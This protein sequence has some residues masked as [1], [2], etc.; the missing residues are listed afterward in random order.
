MKRLK[1]YVRVILHFPLSGYVLRAITSRRAS[2]S[3]EKPSERPSSV[4]I[5]NLIPF[6]GDAVLYLPLVDALKRQRPDIKLSVICCETVSSL[7]SEY[8]GI[9]EVLIVKSVKHAWMQKVPIM[10]DYHRFLTVAFFVRHIGKSR[11]FDVGLIP[12][13][14]AEPF[15]S[16]HAAWLMEIPRIYGYSSKLEPERSFM[17]Y[18]AE[19][20]MSGV[21]DRKGHLHESMRAL[22][23]GELAGLISSG[24]WSADGAIDGLK[25]LASQ[26]NFEEI[27]SKVGL[28]PDDEYAV[29]APGAGAARRQWPAERFREIVRRLEEITDMRILIIGS[30]SELSI[31]EAIAQGFGTRA[32]CIA[33]QLTLPQLVGLLSRARIF[34][35]N[36]SGPGH[37]AGGLGVPTVSLNA[38]PIDGPAGH[39]Q[40]P[41]RNRPPG[42]R[43]E[44]LQPQKLLS[45]CQE[46][47]GA[48]EVHCL[49][50]IQ[51]AEVWEAVLRSLQHA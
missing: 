14:G 36:D 50:Q 34:V 11:S 41:A 26:Q 15:F 35:G 10:R 19:V 24:I 44:V 33:G 39:H 47:C 12:R 22:E 32:R 8:P 18:H 30:R 6:L 20:L 45:P 51:V 13:G 17:W 49:G 40:S 3:Y 37:I 21:V 2:S 38:Y 4:A 23:V 46:E 42:P 48:S 16:A 1:Q 28:R 7:Y 43:V 29:I 5:V 9:E 27:A 25:K 31:G